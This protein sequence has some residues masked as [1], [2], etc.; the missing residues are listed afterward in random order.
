MIQT[1]LAE[2]RTQP[3]IQAFGDA[4]Q[5]LDASFRSLLAC[6]PITFDTRPRNLPVEVVYLFSNGDRPIYVGRSN[7]FRQRLGNHCRNSSQTNQA[8]LAFRLACEEMQHV[9]T[10]YQRGS[11][12]ANILKDVPGLFEAFNR[13][14]LQ[15]RSMEIRYVAEPDQ[16]R[17]GLLEMYAALALGTKHDFGT[18]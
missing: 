2:V 10:K 1:P 18:H 4:I 13:M 17:Q 8:S 9:R 3:C 6:D 16:V 5:G 14:K 15:M 7:N 11:S 12:A